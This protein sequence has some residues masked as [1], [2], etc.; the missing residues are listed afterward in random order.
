MFTTT[1]PATRSYDHREMA[2]IPATGAEACDGF[3]LV[4]QGRKATRYAVTEMSSVG[5]RRFEVRKADGTT[6]RTSVSP[7]RP[8]VFGCTCPAGQIGRLGVRCLHVDSLLAL[9][10]SGDLHDPRNADVETVSGG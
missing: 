6:Y 7:G 4:Q 3:L 9:C 1:L 10:E 2:F 8:Q 5:G